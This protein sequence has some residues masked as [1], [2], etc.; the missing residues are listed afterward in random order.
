MIILWSEGERS[1]STRHGESA[2]AL[3]N[4]SAVRTEQG[5]VVKNN[6]RMVK[7]NIRI[8]VLVYGLCVNIGPE[9]ARKRIGGSS[10]ICNRNSGIIG[11]AIN[12][13]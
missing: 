7:N 2:Y 1:G 5:L 3:L 13:I 10:D 12:A 6:I 9:C 4:E 11:S 8:S